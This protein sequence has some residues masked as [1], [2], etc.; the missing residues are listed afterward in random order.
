MLRRRHHAARLSSAGCSSPSLQFAP[1]HRLRNLRVV[2][3]LVAGE[4]L[5]ERLAGLADLVSTGPTIDFGALLDDLGARG[6]ER[7]MVE[8]GG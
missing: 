6:M 1:A 8:G 2:Q 7:L 3:L 4:K 5:R